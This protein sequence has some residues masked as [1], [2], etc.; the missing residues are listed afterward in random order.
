MEVADEDEGHHHEDVGILLCWWYIVN[1]NLTLFCVL[2]HY[3]YGITTDFYSLGTRCSSDI[4]LS[5]RHGH[6]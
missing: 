5:I 4:T 2:V 1:Y 3:D 6:G